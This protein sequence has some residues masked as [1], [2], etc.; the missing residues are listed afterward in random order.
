[1]RRR[2]PEIS[3]QKKLRESQIEGWAV[4]VARNLRYY[5]RKYKTPSRRS[6]PDRIFAKHGRVFF[7]E[8]KA[9]GSI[10]SDLQKEEH[11]KMRKAGLTVY[12]CDSK[13]SFLA[14]FVPED[15]AINWMDLPSDEDMG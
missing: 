12:V 1:M 7:I 5:A 4:Q 15:E 2:Y 14:V 11:R 10:P 8:F 3:T 13:E 6:A 9:T